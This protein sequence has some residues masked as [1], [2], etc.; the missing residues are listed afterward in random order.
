MTL[1]WECGDPSLG[2]GYYR[3]STYTSHAIC[4]LKLDPKKYFKGLSPLKGVLH[5]VDGGMGHYLSIIQVD[6]WMECWCVLI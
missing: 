5:R 2:R 4:R 6:I 1:P 3:G